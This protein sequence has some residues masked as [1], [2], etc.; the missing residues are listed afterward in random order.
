M[1][2]PRPVISI[3]S[4]KVGE[5]A[6]QALIS[7]GSARSGGYYGI[8]VQLSDQHLLDH[9]REQKR[10]RDAKSE[11]AASNRII[12][13]AQTDKKIHICLAKPESAWTSSDYSTM[14]SFKKQ[15]GDEK[16]ASLVA[17]KKR[18]WAARKARPP[19]ALLSL[20]AIGATL[21]AA[22]LEDA[23]GNPVTPSSEPPVAPTPG[24]LSPELTAALDAA[25][26]QLAAAGGDVDVTSGVMY[27]RHIEK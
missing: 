6:K 24:G 1:K 9:Q 2:S 20:E 14:L 26:A 11:E 4:K 12:R 22:G 15:E 7:M 19:R 10:K 5:E 13:Q 27:S 23:D 18:Q 3:T 21:R 17:D 25:E 16:N 8:S